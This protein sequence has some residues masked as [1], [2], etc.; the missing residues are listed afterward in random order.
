MFQFVW[1]LGSEGGF[2]KLKSSYPETRR[3]FASRTNL[4][5]I[6]KVPMEVQAHTQKLKTHV[7]VNPYDTPSEH[8]AKAFWKSQP[9]GHWQCDISHREKGYAN[10][11]ALVRR[12]LRNAIWQGAGRQLVDRGQLSSFEALDFGFHVELNVLFGVWQ[13][14]IRTSIVAI[15]APSLKRVALM[16]PT[17]A[18]FS[19]AFLWALIASRTF[20]LS[21]ASWVKYSLFSKSRSSSIIPLF[22]RVLHGIH[23]LRWWPCFQHRYCR[24]LDSW[25][26]SKHHFRVSL[27]NK[28]V[29]TCIHNLLFSLHG[30]HQTFSY[31]LPTGF[32]QKTETRFGP[33]R[34][35]PV[36]AGPP[37]RPP[38]INQCKRYHKPIKPHKNHLTNH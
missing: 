3:Q 15:S 29:T 31:N 21:G 33:V 32:P 16:A 17:K 11:T 23:R 38:D 19:C 12:L 1:C 8:P 5:L 7:A 22:L 13:K 34:P 9:L 20:M 4:A 30:S 24:F 14:M 25:E 18:M 35:G 37:L 10:R 36:P 2:I 28:K 26:G 6:W 27:A